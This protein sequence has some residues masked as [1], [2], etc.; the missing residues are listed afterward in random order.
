VKGRADNPF[1]DL[2]VGL[3]ESKV[4][5]IVAGGVAAV[6]HG[7]PRVTMDL[8]ISVNMDEP[9]VRRLLHAMKKLSLTPRAPVPAEVLLDRESREKMVREKGAVVFTFIDRNDPLKHVDIFLAQEL[10]YEKLIRH[11]V[12]EKLEGRSV[13]VVTARYLLTMKQAI[14]PPRAKD[15]LDIRMLTEILEQEDDSR[16]A[17]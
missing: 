8:D 3:L 2:L 5:F 15:L 7:V 4:E 6:L 16:T 9:N 12:K 13:Q 11:A 17:R 1:R 10:A 14:T